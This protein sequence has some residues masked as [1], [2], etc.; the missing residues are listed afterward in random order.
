MKNEKSELEIELFI[1]ENRQLSQYQIEI[2]KQ[3]EKQKAERKKKFFFILLITFMQIPAFII[4]TYFK[5]SIN[6]KLRNN[7]SIFSIT[8]YFVIFSMYFLRLKVYI[9]QY[10]SFGILFIISFIFAIETVCFDDKASLL[11]LLSSFLYFS[12][13]EVFYTLILA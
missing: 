9:H 12:S 8:L 13:Y 3:K 1:N 11:D 10:I 7:I 2:L 4:Q 6:Q 5:E